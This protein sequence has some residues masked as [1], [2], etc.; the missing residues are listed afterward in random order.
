MLL[1]CLLAENSYFIFYLKKSVY[2][3]IIITDSRMHCEFP[4]QSATENTLICYQ[5]K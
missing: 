5:A 2:I 3:I 4:R 1:K